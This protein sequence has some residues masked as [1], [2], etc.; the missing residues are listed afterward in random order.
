ME[1][2]HLNVKNYRKDPIS[3]ILLTQFLF[4]EFINIKVGIK[5]FLIFIPIGWFKNYNYNINV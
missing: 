4:L 3:P 1:Y 5:V 2:Q